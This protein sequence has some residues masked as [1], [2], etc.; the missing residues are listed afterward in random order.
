MILTGILLSAISSLLIGLLGGIRIGRRRQTAVAPQPVHRAL[1][2]KLTHPSDGLPNTRGDKEAAPPSTVAPTRIH[3]TGADSRLADESTARQLEAIR[4][5]FVANVSH[6]LKAPVAAVILLAEAVVNAANEPREVRRFG[7]KIFNEAN[8]LSTLLTELI[9]LS[10]LE[11]TE[12]LPEPTIVAVDEVV[13][14]ALRRCQVAAESSGI[15]ITLDPPHPT[16]LVVEGDASLLVTALSNLL[17]NAVA[18]SPPGSPVSVSRRLVNGFVDIAVADHG[19]GIAPEYQERVF[20]RFFHL[21]PARSRA[22]GSTG[23]G[24]AIVKH[25]AVN[26]GGEIQLTSTP[27]VG[28]TFTL[29]IPAHQDGSVNAPPMSAYAG[30]I[31]WPGR[32]CRQSNLKADDIPALPKR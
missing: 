1:G 3:E 26:H 19:P 9:T 23:L 28:S 11:A 29:R 20:E 2:T 5:D 10:R 16:E 31:R 17:D 6:E 22:T 30:G 15:H 25:V 8:R 18:Y 4:R 13:Q 21:D 24:L 7:T 12:R 27:G 14:E 32:S